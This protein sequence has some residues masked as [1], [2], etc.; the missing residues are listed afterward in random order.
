[1]GDVVGA[2]MTGVATG[3]IAKV[4][5]GEEEYLKV[6]A[7]GAG[8]H[9]AASYGMSV[10]GM[11]GKGLTLLASSALYAAVVPQVAEGSG[12]FGMDFLTG[13][14]SNLAGG[15][16]QRVSTKAGVLGTVTPPSLSVSTYTSSTP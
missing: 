8:S 9:L 5:N 12:S 15:V 6:G 7:V 10:V 13:V 11:G 3:A 14:A 1:M 4:W 2:V 16:I